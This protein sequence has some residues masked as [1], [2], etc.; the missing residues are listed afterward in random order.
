MDFYKNLTVNMISLNDLCQMNNSSATEK[1]GVKLKSAKLASW[2]K[3]VVGSHLS[4][5]TPDDSPVHDVGDA[6]YRTAIVLYEPRQRLLQLGHIVSVVVCLF[7]LIH[8][9]HSIGLRKTVSSSVVRVTTT[10]QI[11]T[12]SPS[13]CCSLRYIYFI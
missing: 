9:N 13:V 12:N 5:V 6:L 11:G 3:S 2:R 7:N 4:P 10:Q 8:V 1:G